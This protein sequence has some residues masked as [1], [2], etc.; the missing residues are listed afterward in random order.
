VRLIIDNIGE[1]N[2]LVLVD[3]QGQYFVSFKVKEN[4]DYEVIAGGRNER[5]IRDSKGN[6]INFLGK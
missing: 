2:F 6:S 4:I 3:K 5:I 1:T